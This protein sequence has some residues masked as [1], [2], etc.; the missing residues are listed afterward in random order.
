MS[1]V[2]FSR[3]L[4]PCSCAMWCV[5]VCVCVGVCGCVQLFKFINEVEWPIVCLHHCSLCE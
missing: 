2:C 3:Y 5:G 4:V 1:D